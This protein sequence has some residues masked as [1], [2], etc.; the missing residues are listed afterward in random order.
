[1]MANAAFVLE[2]EYQKSPHFEKPREQSAATA[3]SNDD[4]RPIT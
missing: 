3:S 2:R 1:M 4:R